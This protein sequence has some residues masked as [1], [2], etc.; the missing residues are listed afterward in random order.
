MAVALVPIS[1]M[2]T[3]VFYVSLYFTFADCFA[4]NDTTGVGQPSLT[5]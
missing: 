2:L 5:P 3:T 1:L 4:E